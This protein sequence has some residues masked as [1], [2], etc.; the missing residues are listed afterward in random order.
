MSRQR[1]K[2]TVARGGAGQALVC[3]RPTPCNSTEAAAAVTYL[4]AGTGGGGFSAG[5]LA[6]S[7]STCAIAQTPSG[8]PSLVFT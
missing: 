3:E 7:K 6:D 4:P 8:V 1:H 2:E 5:I